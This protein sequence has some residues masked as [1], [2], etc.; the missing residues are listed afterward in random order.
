MHRNAL[1]HDMSKKQQGPAWA[2]GGEIVRTHQHAM[3]I[4]VRAQAQGLTHLVPQARHV[5]AKLKRAAEVK[6]TASAA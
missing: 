4:L 3:R 1:E 2:L 5:H 6:A